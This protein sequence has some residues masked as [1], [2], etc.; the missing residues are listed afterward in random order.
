M[1]FFGYYLTV[2]ILF[3]CNSIIIGVVQSRAYSKA[4]VWLNGLIVW[5][6]APVVSLRGGNV[7]SIKSGFN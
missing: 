1:L 2:F 7:T 5:D 6:E 3:P 4:S